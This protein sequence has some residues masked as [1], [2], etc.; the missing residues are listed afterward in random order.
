MKRE[1]V[2]LAHCKVCGR[3]LDE[4][5]IFRYLHRS[6]TRFVLCPPPSACFEKV[7][8]AERVSKGSLARLLSELVAL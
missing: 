6:K 2:D 8:A 7:I 4:D 5:A 1:P 3:H